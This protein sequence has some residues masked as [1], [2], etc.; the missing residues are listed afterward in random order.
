MRPATDICVD[1]RAPLVPIGSLITLDNDALAFEQNLLDGPNRLAGQMR[2][3]DI[4]HVQERG[5]LEADIDERRLHAGQDANDPP[6]IDVAHQA[7][8]G[9]P[10]DV[11]FLHGPL[12][13]H[14][15]A[16]LLGRKVDQDLFKAWELEVES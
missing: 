5:A 2:L 16:R 3:P 15:N 12:M 4:G 8:R 10:F 6:D 14:G 11:Q 13:E 1:R 9:P 7:A